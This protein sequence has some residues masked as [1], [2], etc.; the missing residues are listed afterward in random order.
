[1]TGNSDSPPSNLSGEVKHDRPESPDSARQ[2]RGMRGFWWTRVDADSSSSVSAKAHKGQRLYRI[3]ARLVTCAM[4]LT[5]LVMLTAPAPLSADSPNRPLIVGS[6]QDYPPFA[7][8]TNAENADGFTV[9]LWKEVAKT[10]GLPYEIRVSTFNDILQGFKSGSVDVMI[11]LAQSDERRKFADFSVTHVTVNGAIFVRKGEHRISAESDLT[12]KSIIVIK[13]DLAHDYAVGKGWEHQLVLVDTAQQ[14]LREL[15][16]GKHDA[17]LLSHLAG[18]QTIRSFRL[19]SLKALEVKVGFSQCFSFAVR[20]GNTVLLARINEGLALSWSNGVNDRLHEK[21]FGRY[22]SKPRTLLDAWPELTAA[23]VLVMVVGAVTYYRR[24]RRDQR[25][26]VTLRDSEDRW[27][28]ALDGIG[29]GVWD[30]NFATGTTLYSTRW[31]EM[32]GYSEREISSD[33]KEWKRRVHLDDIDRVLADKQLCI[34]GVTNIFSSE[35]RMRTKT[36]HWLWIVA[37]GKAIGRDADG[38]ALRIIGTY[39]DIS[40]RKARQARDAGYAA[41]MTL[42]ASNASLSVILASIAQRV[43]AAGNWQCGFTLSDATST[44]LLTDATS[45]QRAS[46][47]LGV[48]AVGAFEAKATEGAAAS[49]ADEQI[50]QTEHIDHIDQDRQTDSGWESYGDLIDKAAVLAC[51]SQPIVG[52]AGVILGNFAVYHSRPGAPTSTEASVLAEF[53]QLAALAIERKRDEQDLRASEQRL[54]LALEASSL[55]LWDT[56]VTTG[57]VFLSEAWTEMLGGAYQPT[58]STVEELY[59]LIP[60]EDQV[61]IYAAASDTLLG[62][63]DRYSVDHR[64]V[65]PDGEVMWVQT[66]G[67][68]VERTADGRPLRVVGTSRDINERVQAQATQRQLESRL[69]EAQRLEAIGTLAGGIAHDFNNIMAAILGN[70]ALAQ[71]DVERGGDVHV[72][73]NQIHKAG[74]RARSLVQK[75]LAFSRH[76]PG[77]SSSLSLRPLVEETFLML[78][79]MVGPATQLRTSLPDRPLRVMGDA[80]QLQQV[81]LNLGTNAWQA[82][83]GGAGSIEFGLKEIILGDDAVPAPAGL[84]PGA[85]VHLWV[86]DDGCGMDKATRQRIFEPFFTTKLVDQGTGL[87]LAVVHGIVESHGGV[88][89]VTSAPGQGSTFDVYLPQV[90]DDN[91]PAPL[92]EAPVKVVSGR[93]QH[94]LYV[95]DDDVMVVMVQSLLERLGYR[96][97]CTQ[98]ANEAIDWVKRY[99][100]KF[101]L[102]V[103]DFNMPRM[104]GLDVSRRLRELCP[105]L[106]VVISSGY[107]SETMRADAAELGVRAVVHKEYTFEEIGS[108]IDSILNP[109][110]RL[111]VQDVQDAEHRRIE[112]SAFA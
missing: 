8:G 40:E 35:F 21:W 102:V 33:P 76:Q 86:R 54:Q 51:W 49:G 23:V 56:N 82:L 107:I 34:D 111:G 43:E 41:V 103:T 48:P 7:I 27:K 75:I 4:T 106:P 45:P 9:E 64:Y 69:R 72:Y 104:T 10:Q 77:E 83:E 55:S 32:L 44:Q 53:A 91:V 81:V 112:S 97:T 61:K 99:P 78:R 28:F 65:R 63:A 100:E 59:R 19:S 12:G 30:T 66:Q 90:S 42:L 18:M 71:Q 96:A 89:A 95:D 93:G 25:A 22:E 109:E 68:V 6:E 14:G 105:D 3:T 101:D 38:N 62:L 58:R 70:V 79:S 98:D 39:S 50:D 80:T 1:M 24:R 17:M 37:R 94:V 26:A 46:Y 110:H 85:Y 92:E 31:K 15:A 13:G 2:T 108:V 29:D 5:A 88:I 52:T 74:H 67:R 20:K 57:E 36:G 84:A 16:S 87:G 11:N 73:L 47:K 60:E